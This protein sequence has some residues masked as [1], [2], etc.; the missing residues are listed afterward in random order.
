MA[1][2]TR[3]RRRISEG[4]SFYGL[5][6]RGHS[7]PLRDGDSHF[8]AS[9]QRRCYRRRAGRYG[10]P[11]RR[12][13]AT[14]EPAPALPKPSKEGRSGAW[15]HFPPMHSARRSLITRPR[16]VPPYRRVVEVSTC[17]NAL[18]QPS[19]RDTGWT[20]MI[21]FARFQRPARR[22]AQGIIGVPPVFLIPAKGDDKA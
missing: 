4:A 20:L 16:P 13:R 7:S 12:V 8:R 10:I 15:N 3:V 9:C 17:W 1:R 21:L 19:F 2:A 5:K 11:D 14:D 18:I 6:K 22:R